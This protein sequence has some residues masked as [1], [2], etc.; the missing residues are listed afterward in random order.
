MAAIPAY[1]RGENY[2]E[3][4]KEMEIMLSN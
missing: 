4:I 3:K 1:L 2:L